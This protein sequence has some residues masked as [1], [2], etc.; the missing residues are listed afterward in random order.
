MRRIIFIF[1]VAVLLLGAC[2]KVEKK[3]TAAPPTGEV[4][5]TAEEVETT[6]IESELNDVLSDIDKVNSE[7]DLE[8]DISQQIALG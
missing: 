2:A 1:L 4:E 7:L 5:T 6:T 8:T 3:I